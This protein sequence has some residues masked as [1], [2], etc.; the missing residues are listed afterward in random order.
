M[1]GSRKEAE[2]MAAPTTL[3]QLIWVVL[4]WFGIIFGVPLMCLLIYT[5]VTR[6][7][8][9]R[10]KDEHENEKH[11]EPVPCLNC[12]T[13]IDSTQNTCPKCGWTWK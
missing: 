9:K 12:R 1:A 4:T 8:F 10:R 3:L 11:N 2:T 13:M 5:C 7:F 6:G